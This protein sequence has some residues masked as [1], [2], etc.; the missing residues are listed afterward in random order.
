MTRYVEDRDLP[1]PVGENGGTIESMMA[2]L[3]SHAVDHAG[4][5]SSAT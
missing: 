1:K 3:G 2:L 5:I 4:Q